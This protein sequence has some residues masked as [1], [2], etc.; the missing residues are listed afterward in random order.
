MLAEAR[1][2]H[3]MIDPPVV[4]PPQDNIIP[5]DP[6]RCLTTPSVTRPRSTNNRLNKNF[7][8]VPTRL[9]HI[10][11][12]LASSGSAVR[13]SFVQFSCKNFFFLGMRPIYRSVRSP[14]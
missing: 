11:V 8:L 5:P 13:D 3:G 4:A 7:S 14:L 6:E 10:D 1:K 9:L 2:S 12:A